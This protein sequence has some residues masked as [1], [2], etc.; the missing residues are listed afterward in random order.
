MKCH[1]LLE[2]ERRY[3]QPEDPGF[4][5]NL[6]VDP[7][8]D[9]SAQAVEREQKRRNDLASEVHD[10]ILKHAQP[11]LSQVNPAEF[12]LYRGLSYTYKRLFLQSMPENRQPKD[13]DPI[14]HEAYNAM[15]AAVGGKANRSNAIFG[16]PSVSHTA[17]YGT[18]YALI[19]L[20]DFT[21]TLS[22]D[23]EDWTQDLDIDQL[24]T[25]LNDR[26]LHGV[27]ISYFYTRSSLG[28]A[29]SFDEMQKGGYRPLVLKYVQQRTTEDLESGRLTKDTDKYSLQV[30]MNKNSYDVQ[31]LQNVI[32]VDQGLTSNDYNEVMLR[33]NK[34]L[35]IEYD[36][37]HRVQSLFK[38]TTPVAE[39]VATPRIQL[40]WHHSKTKRKSSI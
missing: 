4:K 25:L 19:P 3:P 40:P 31:K 32:L 15:I 17:Q 33:S 29:L 16:S 6:Y 28:S 18:P 10:Y 1:E 7:D 36:F 39:T 23:W 2:A 9:G 20:G 24:C 11:W 34:V 26:S 21:Y 14:R 22:T 27:Y 12:N 13:T 30:L 35:H 5:G 8:S 38:K 37:W